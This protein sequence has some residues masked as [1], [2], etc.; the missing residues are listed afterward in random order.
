MTALKGQQFRVLPPPELPEAMDSGTEFTTVQINV[1]LYLP[2]LLSQCVKNGVIVTRGILAHISE[3]RN[4]HH[5]GSQADV[6]INC[7]GLSASKLGGVYDKTV[8]PA[9]GQTVIVR[10]DPGV[11]ACTSDDGEEDIT[12]I[13]KRA[14]GK[15][16]PSGPPHL[17]PSKPSL[18]SFLPPPALLPASSILTDLQAA[19]QSSAA[20]TN[21]T[22]GNRNPI[23]TSRSRS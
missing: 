5:S 19:A 22:T 9:R 18:P 1:S 17:F 14:V 15:P 4:L 2:W 3:A 12:Y 16:S 10:N 23:P 7:T 13:Q 8:I 21:S 6:I 11:M 20:P